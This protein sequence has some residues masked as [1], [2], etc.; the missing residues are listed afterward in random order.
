MLTPNQFAWQS[1]LKS[2]FCSLMFLCLVGIASACL[3]GVG[4][5]NEN[6]SSGIGQVKGRIGADLI[7]VP[8]SYDKAAKDALFAGEACTILFPE[9]PDTLAGYQRIGIPGQFTALSENAGVQLL[10]HSGTS[11]HCI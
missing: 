11:A 3:F 8:S 2:R 10:L 1:I 7:A 4:F 9:N 6:L 5:F